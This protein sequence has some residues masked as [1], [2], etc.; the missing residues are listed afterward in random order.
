MRKLT[1]RSRLMTK[2]NRASKKRIRESDFSLIYC[3]NV[4]YYISRK[5]WSDCDVQ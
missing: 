4:R 1:G 2:E 3:K 5:N